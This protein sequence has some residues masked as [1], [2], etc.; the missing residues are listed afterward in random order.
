MKKLK[1]GEAAENA[2]FQKYRRE[3]SVRGLAFS[4]SRTEF[5]AL[6]HLNCRYCGSEPKHTFGR[7]EWNGRIVYNG[8]DRLDNSKGYTVEN[9]VPCC[10]Q[11]N[12]AKGGMTVAQFKKWVADVCRNSKT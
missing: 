6:I 12:L 10:F 5:G 4:L 1:S 9:C 7:K 2:L 11:C 3:S 8:L